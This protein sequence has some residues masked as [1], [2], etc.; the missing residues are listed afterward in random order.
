LSDAAGS[1]GLTGRENPV[2][3]C[4]M[5]RNAYRDFNARRIEAVLQRMSADVMWANGMEGGHVYGVDAVREY[6]QRQF[7]MLSP[8]VEPIS[9][10]RNADGRFEVR[11]HQTVRD[12]EGKLLLDT[13]VRHFYAIENGFI[14]RMDINP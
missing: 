2:D 8:N 7:A 4:E 3:E 13:E 5:L 12:L 9:I 1:A 6:W 14:A 11:V 10:D